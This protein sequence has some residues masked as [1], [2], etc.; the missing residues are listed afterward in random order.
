VPA[1]L[2][3]MAAWKIFTELLRPVAGEPAWEFVERVQGT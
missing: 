1:V 2:A 3:F